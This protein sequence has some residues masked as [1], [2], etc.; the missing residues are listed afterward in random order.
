MRYNPSV[1]EAPRNQNTPIVRPA[2]E[3]TILAWLEQQ[4]RL[5]AYETDNAGNKI[6]PPVLPMKQHG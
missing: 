1:S 6:Y 3:E 5:I 2:T 4:G